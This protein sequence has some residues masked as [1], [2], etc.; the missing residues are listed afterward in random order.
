MLNKCR[1]A[2]VSMAVLLLAS[3]PGVVRTN[4][5]REVRDCLMTIAGA[6]RAKPGSI[7]GLLGKACSGLFVE[8]GCR[9]AWEKVGSFPPEKRASLLMEACRDAYCPKLEEPRPGA[10]SLELPDGAAERLE[11]WRE[12]FWAIWIRDLGEA[13]AIHLKGQLMALSSAFYPIEIEMPKKETDRGPVVTIHVRLDGKRSW[14]SL[15][16][17]KSKTW[18]LPAVPGPKDLQP[19]LDAVASLPGDRRAILEV[20]PEVPYSLVM[21]VMDAL[22]EVGVK[23]LVLAVSEAGKDGEGSPGPR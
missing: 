6:L 1:W 16:S 4:T 15:P 12:L 18:T 2:F 8:K 5:D 14:V 23:N 13:R 17:D 19:I 21:S 20:K 11:L 3:S 9:E 22:R 7:P 10:C